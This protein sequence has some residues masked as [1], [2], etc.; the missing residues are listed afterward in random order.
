MQ[1]ISRFGETFFDT[2]FN[3]GR[4]GDGAVQV[5]GV[6]VDITER[7]RAEEALRQANLV[8]E[9]SPAMLFRWKAEDGWPVAFVS[10]NVTQLGY[11]PEELLDGSFRFASLVYLSLIHI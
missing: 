4:D 7:Q 1:F 6:A 10:H 5:M 11:S 9:N 2:Y 8:V 3:P